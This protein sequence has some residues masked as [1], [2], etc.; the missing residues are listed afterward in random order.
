M[1]WTIDTRPKKLDDLYGLE[2]LKKYIKNCQLKNDWPT[3]MMLKG[4]FGTGK[5]TVAMIVSATMNCEY[6]DK[7]GN[8]CGVCSSCKSIFEEKFDRDVILIDGGTTGKAEVTDIIDTFTS[9]G[10]LRDKKK[11][12]IIEEIQELSTAAKDSLLK[13]LESSRKNIHYILLSMELQ[14]L[15]GFG[16][17]CASP[18]IFKPIPTK[19]IMMFLHE[20]MKKHKYWNDP[21][22]PDE[23]KLKGLS[24]IAQA[25]GG[26][27]RQALQTLETCIKSEYFT[28]KEITDNLDIINEESAASL[29][30]RFLNKDKSSLKEIATKN[31]FDF[32]NLSY[33]IISNAYAYKLF[34]YLE[35]DYIDSFVANTKAL[36]NHENFSLLV[37][38][39]RELAPQSKPFLRK[40]DLL[41]ML[42]KLFE[43]ILEKDSRNGSINI[44][45]TKC[46][47]NYSH[48]YDRVV[49]DS[50]TQNSISIPLKT[51]KIAQE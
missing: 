42:S 5:T 23:F 12:I 45:N 13:K 50:K 44:D 40:A 21:K 24:A 19:D 18:V 28:E 36:A 37:E 25:S 26:S 3:A 32:F 31:P 27:Y 14:G 29:L 33:A 11:V 34:D 4:K 15:S 17:R 51:R 35:N 6:P 2:G 47:L 9:T 22:I 43:K 38:A 10:P 8:P 49:S 7:D 1:Q 39:Y 48:Y 20:F 16:S 46:S 41:M 30:L